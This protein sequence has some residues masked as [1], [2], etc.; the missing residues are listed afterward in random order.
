MPDSR[1]FVFQLVDERYHQEDWVG[2]DFCCTNIK[3]QKIDN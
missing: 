2:H 3:G 1:L